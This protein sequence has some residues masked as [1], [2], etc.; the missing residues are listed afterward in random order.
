M[1]S[2]P[3]NHGKQPAFVRKDKGRECT[4]SPFGLIKKPLVLS[5]ILYLATI[6]IY[7]IS[8]LYIDNVS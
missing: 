7:S 3:V 5:R 1:T 6:Y 2:S 4:K 8:C